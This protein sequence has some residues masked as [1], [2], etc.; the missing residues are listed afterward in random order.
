MVARAAVGD[1]TRA[2]LGRKLLRRDPVGLLRRRRASG[3]P[4][5]RDL[6]A[7][8]RRRDPLPGRRILDRHA[9][10]VGVRAGH[11]GA[12]A[13]VEGVGTA[14]RP[15]RLPSGCARDPAC[16]RGARGT[17]RGPAVL[18][19]LGR[20]QRRRRPL[21]GADALRTG[22]REHPAGHSRGR[23]A[24][25]VPGR[26][27]GGLRRTPRC[28]A[29]GAPHHRRLG[30]RCPRDHGDR[31]PRGTALLPRGRRRGGRTPRRDRRR[32]PAGAGDLAPAAFGDVDGPHRRRTTR[33]KR[34]RAPHRRADIPLRPGGPDAGRGRTHAQ[35]LLRRATQ[36][37]H[38]RTPG[39]CP[40]VHR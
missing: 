24:G 28:G 8:V 30:A 18:P 4:G 13:A 17:W 12:V 23:M 2:L 31:R 16:R 26:S 38:P 5:H 33:P 11:P 20:A 6:G 10:H 21:V 19:R 25:P 29:P 35:S 27:A 1:R 7:A 40:R 15:P 39:R 34:C 22:H 3:R 32:W 36:T 9:A 14:A 37:K